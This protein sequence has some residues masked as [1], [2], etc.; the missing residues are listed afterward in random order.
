[1][2]KRLAY[3][4]DRHGTYATFLV[5]DYPLQSLLGL[6]CAQ[7]VCESPSQENKQIPVN[8][9][10]SKQA[11]AIQGLTRLIRVP[12]LP[13]VTRVALQLPNGAVT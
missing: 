1:M 12:Q 8:T 7:K 3:I 4:V 5:S 13:S 10:P 9:R 11:W 2:T 6:L